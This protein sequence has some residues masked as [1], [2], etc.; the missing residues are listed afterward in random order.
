MFHYF[1]KS[2][3]ST[4][5]SIAELL[6]YLGLFSAVALVFTGILTEV[7]DTNA[8][9]S[10]SNEL[11]S[12][13]NTVLAVVQ[14]YVKESSQIEVYQD[15]AH[16]SSPT[17]T[18][19]Y[20]MIRTGSSSTDPTC[21]YLNGGA[22]KLAVGPDALNKSE[23]TSQAT[24]L[25]TN[26]V[27]ADSLEFMVA[28]QVG[29]HAF[30][31]VDARFSANTANPRLAI[32]KEISSAIGRA[33]AA[34]F[35]SDLIPNSDNTFSIGQT[36]PDLRWRNGS[37]SGTVTLG[38]GASGGNLGIGTKTP[39]G[40]LDVVASSNHSLLVT[41]AG[42]VGIGTSAPSVKLDV[43]G[44]IKTM[45]L[46]VGTSTQN[47]PNV[48]ASFG[49]SPTIPSNR[50]INIDQILNASTA[51]QYLFMNGTLGSA[52]NMNYP[53][54]TSPYAPCF[55]L[56]SNDYNLNVLAAPIGT[57][58]TTSVAL[59]FDSF[60]NIGIGTT[61]P[62]QKL[63]VIGNIRASG[64]IMPGS[65]STPPTT[66][67]TSSASS[68][69]YNSSDTKMY[70]CNG[71]E[72]K[73]LGAAGQFFGD[74]SD[75]AFFST[76][77]T[78]LAASG[79]NVLVK[80][81]S[82]FTLNTGNILTIDSPVQ[83]L[84]LLVQGDV[85]ING[86]INMNYLAKNINPATTPTLYTL[87]STQSDHAIIQTITAL[88]KMRIIGPGGN[89]GAGGKGG[90]AYAASATNSG[91][92]GGIGGPGRWSG[93]GIGGGGGGG[94]A[95]PVTYI[96]SSC[97][98]MYYPGAGGTGVLYQTSFSGGVPTPTTTT[99]T[100]YY[101]W[102][103]SSPGNQ[104]AGGAGGASSNGCPNG[105]NLPGSGASGS[106]G[107]GGGGGGSSNL[108]VGGSGLAGQGL[109]GGTIII[110]S[111][112]NVTINNGGLIT[113]N[114]GNGGAG[115]GGVISSLL[116]YAIAASGGGG[117]GGSGGGVVTIV[118]KN[119]YTNSGSITVNGGNGGAGGS[120]CQY[121]NGNSSAWCQN[122]SAGS[123]GSPGTITILKI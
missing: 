76:G 38:T 17:T 112:G 10:S 60:G 49:Y 26:K 71:T 113:A 35:D 23:C 37:F 120:P 39:L 78:T 64:V 41:S 11:V 6:I 106:N 40:L 115:G 63:D 101:A 109:G 28:S 59:S 19:S 57:N 98:G 4:G 110:I 86:T 46:L 25:T 85:T 96:S 34:V 8:R 13:L 69:Y 111:G 75:G 103:I 84:V 87:G 30:V 58:T 65:T 100:Y 61:Q 45:S 42:N 99:D 9:N 81:Y 92:T 15:S 93:G 94:A 114:G 7:V 24:D 68:I 36:S 105:T 48:L 82:S 43:Y 54:C 47:Y 80:Q 32:S 117:G 22:V 104:S 16:L 79:A 66:C 62:G 73:I 77:N 21:I 88:S 70:Y 1:R 91:G 51:K 89:G 33:N 44:G 53:Y 67:T 90:D 116:G 72:W 102:Y 123:S 29:G 119:N 108:G 50:Q 20:L 12:Q 14:K 118:Y 18:G 52:T 121:Y 3:H 5:F 107:A 27:V 2:A 122:G 55:A 56:E 95:A 83:A 31:K 74:G 97:G